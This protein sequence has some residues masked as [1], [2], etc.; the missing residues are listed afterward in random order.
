MW[1][2]SLIEAR[3]IDS[4]SSKGEGTRR[5]GIV[6]IAHRLST[7]RNSDLI[8]VLSR[9]EVCFLL[10]AEASTSRFDEMWDTPIRLSP[11][12]VILPVR[13]SCMY[14]LINEV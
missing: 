1:D 9:G 2:S 7:I 10:E 3:T 11:E 5:L 4:I 8:Y 13:V 6:S 12:T 14:G